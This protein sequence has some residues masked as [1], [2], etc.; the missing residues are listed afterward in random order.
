[1]ARSKKHSAGLARRSEEEVVRALELSS[2]ERRR[3]LLVRMY[4]I[5]YSVRHAFESLVPQDGLQNARRRRIY[6]PPPATDTLIEVSEDGRLCS[7]PTTT[8]TS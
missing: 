3:M 7:V 1:M 6:L 4:Q 5:F 2:E 8:G